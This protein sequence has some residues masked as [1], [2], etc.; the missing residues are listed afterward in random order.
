MV[1]NK[2]K[3]TTCLFFGEEVNLGYIILRKKL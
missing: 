1:P 3:I 2:K